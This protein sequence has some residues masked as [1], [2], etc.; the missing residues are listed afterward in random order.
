[1]QE[2]SWILEPADKEDVFTD[3]P[4]NLWSSVLRRKGGAY[5]MLALMPFDPSEN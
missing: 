2:S 3:R 4:E 1:L 5:S